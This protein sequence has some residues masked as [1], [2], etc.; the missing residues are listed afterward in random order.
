MKFYC[1]NSQQTV[2]CYEL[3]GFH[4]ALYF[5]EMIQC[6]VSL[7]LKLFHKHTEWH[8]INYLMAYKRTL[9][10]ALPNSLFYVFSDLMLWTFSW[11]LYFTFYLPTHKAPRQ[12]KFPTYTAPRHVIY[13]QVTILLSLGWGRVHWL[14]MDFSGVAQVSDS[15]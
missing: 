5:K 12:G 11:N 6:K 9:F 7:W 4:T 1:A 13:L 10:S 8:V 15:G 2:A 3:V 14:R